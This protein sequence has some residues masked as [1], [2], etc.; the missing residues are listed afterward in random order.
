MPGFVVIVSFGNGLTF[1]GLVLVVQ[2]SKIIIVTE[3]TIEEDYR[4]WDGNE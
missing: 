3:L 1:M 4:A 2:E